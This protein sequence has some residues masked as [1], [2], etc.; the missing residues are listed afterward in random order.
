MCAIVVLARFDSFRDT[1]AC[2]AQTQCSNAKHA[3]PQGAV[4]PRRQY[5]ARATLCHTYPAQHRV[6]INRRHT[7]RSRRDAVVHAVQ[8]ERRRQRERRKHAWPDMTT[9]TTH[10]YKEHQPRLTPARRHTRLIHTCKLAPNLAPRVLPAVQV[11]VCRRIV[12][13]G[14]RQR[15]P[16]SRR[17]KE[18]ELRKRPCSHQH[19]GSPQ[20]TTHP[21]HTT[22]LISTPAPQVE[23][24]PRTQPRCNVP[25]GKVCSTPPLVVRLAGP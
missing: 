6:Q 22:G 9:Q 25:T 17:N 1:R 16:K 24:E 4:T 23:N 13:A 21:S 8:H 15:G 14:G 7:K 18:H 19:Q 3:H 2:T 5:I 12:A 20:P 11:E 10:T